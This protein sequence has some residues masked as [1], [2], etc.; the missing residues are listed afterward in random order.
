MK[1]AP[2]ISLFL[3]FA[4]LAAGLAGC[5][6][7]PSSG[8]KDGTAI[9]ANPARVT[10]QSEEIQFQPPADGAPVAVIE[11]SH[12]TLHVV[13][14]EKLAPL[15]VEN[16][17]VLAQSGYYNDAEFHRVVEGFVV[18]TGDP[19]GTGQGGESIWGKPFAHEYSGKLH[20]YAGALCMAS[21][22]GQPG[23]NQSQFYFVVA[24]PDSVGEAAQ[25]ILRAGGVREAVID[26]Y[27]QVG[28]LPYLDYTDTVFGQV[29]A[30]LE[31]LDS[32]AQAAVDE[33]N[34]PKDPVVIQSISI[35][36]QGATIYEMPSPDA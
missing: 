13:L 11:T 31:V 2:L 18:Q 33:N 26:A 5:G 21:E 27:S 7:S 17:C 34:R 10:A 24:A 4:L 19:G 6:G 29:Y 1:H 32:I 16:F 14:Y 35:G 25:E 3:V 28:G 8:A 30:G 36:N 23:T 12:G 20:H 9:G 15:A 22:N